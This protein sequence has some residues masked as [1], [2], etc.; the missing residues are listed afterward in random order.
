MG[1]LHTL[2]LRVYGKEGTLD[3]YKQLKGIVFNEYHSLF[4]LCVFLG[5]KNNKKFSAKKKKEQL[6]WSETFTPHEYASFYSLIIKLSEDGTYDLLKDGEGTLNL[7]QE[8]ADAGLNLF[9]DSKEIKPFV[10]KENDRITMDFSARDHIQ[11]QVMYYVY[12]LYQGI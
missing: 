12:T 9:L 7:L 2:K 4:S 6:F 10:R 5:F 11:K 1:P 3:I 8:Y